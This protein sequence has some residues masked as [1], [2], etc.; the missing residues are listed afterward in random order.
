MIFI[1]AD[2][3]HPAHFISSGNLISE[4]GFVHM[5]RTLDEFVFLMIAEGELSVYANDQEYRLG[6][7]DFLFFLPGKRHYGLA[8]SKGHLS[9]YWTHFTLDPK[10]YRF[11]D[12][13][14]ET[15]N[16]SPNAM[17]LDTMQSDTFSQSQACSC[18]L[19]ESGHLSDS[20]RIT[21]LFV[22]LLDIAKRGGFRAGLQCSYA[23][24]TLLLELSNETL[25]KNRIFA[26]HE[27]LSPRI[28]D[29]LAWLQLNYDSDLSVAELA[30]RFGYHPAYLTSLFKKATGYTIVEYINH[31]RIQAAKNLL[32]TP[33]RLTIGEISEMVGFPD[34]KY[35]MKLFK[36]YEGITPTGYRNAFS[37]KGLNRN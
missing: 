23:L 34:E 26:A 17:Q 25:I 36:R 11:M 2:A 33:P 22:Q 19:P 14:P 30:T 35:F 8:P 32:L 4:D 27:H 1:E 24:S 6:P 29:L 37:K 21:L 16:S 10:S 3:S 13:I 7:E 12:S 28:A 15:H 31:K 9:Y 20:S 18:L 5:N